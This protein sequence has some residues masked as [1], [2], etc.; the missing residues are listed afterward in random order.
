MVSSRLIA[1]IGELVDAEIEDQISKLREE[2][3][4]L[5]VELNSMK[6]ELNSVVKLYSKLKYENEVLKKK[7]T[8]DGSTPIHALQTSNED[9]EGEFRLLPTQYSEDDDSELKSS[10]VK[11]SPHKQDQGDIFISPKKPT[12][13]VKPDVH[14]MSTQ[15]TESSSPDKG[16]DE[17]KW[18]DGDEVVADSQQEGE[19]LLTLKPL[20]QEDSPQKY[21]QDDALIKYLEDA[22]PR[23]KLKRIQVITSYYEVMFRAN[24]VNKIQIRI[25]MKFNPIL[26][27]EWKLA[28][29]KPNPIWTRKRMVTYIKTPQGKTFERRIG[30]SK[31]EEDNIRKFYQIVNTTGTGKDGVIIEQREEDEPQ[32]DYVSEEDLEYEDQISQIYD[33]L[34]SPPGFMQSEFPDTAEQVRRRDIINNRQYRRIQRRI[35]AC[36]QINK[37]GDQVGE[38]VFSLDILNEYVRAKRFIKI[39]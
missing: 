37:Y 36:L 39:D 23:T 31:S 9:G 24:S 15:Y 14:M 38:F 5:K 30:L 32:A 7:V 11:I 18:Q 8:T 12:L 35:K 34:P 4:Q 2:N 10:P 6:F 29:F 27:Q 17:D 16:G 21:K 26:E 22:K 28:D 33:K 1:S 13:N 3:K 20:S 25:S 19:E